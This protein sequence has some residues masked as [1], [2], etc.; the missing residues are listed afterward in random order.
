[1]DGYALCQV[2]ELI[3]HA[4]P[5]I[6]SGLLDGNTLRHLQ[7]A[8]P[9][10]PPACSIGAFECRL[11]AGARQVDLEVCLREGGGGRASL[12]AGLP[13][14][15]DST[16]GDPRWARTIE[17]L[18]SWCHPG[19]PL[20]DTVPVV[21]L[22]LDVDESETDSA[23]PFVVF[24]LDPE[25]PFANGTM[26]TE[27]TEGALLTGL[28]LLAGDELGHSSASTLR[29]C[30]LALP[31]GTRLLH[32]AL[33]PTVDR[34]LLRIILRMEWRC[35]TAYLCHL[36]WRGSSTE[37]DAWLTRTCPTT[38]MSS[39]NLDLADGVGP[40]IGI[41]YYFPTQPASDPRWR[42]VFDALVEV[43]A[44]TEER[45]A[46]LEAW[47]SYGKEH[48]ETGLL[49]VEREL[50]LKVVYEQGQPLR[51]KAYLSFAPRLN[52]TALAGIASHVATE[53]F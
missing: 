14:F 28:N 46:Q 29:R 15:E 35:L 47:P 53:V 4:R 38:L 18:R 37:Q 41:E 20:F 11:E 17:F 32:A 25:A 43:G 3:A 33:R 9:A 50:L 30:L 7:D 2:A 19:S 31:S 27:R 16:R 39:I 5:H 23:V 48:E 52:V 42:T 36:G 22:E 1:M 49:R 21:W 34:D 10:L 26:L 13:E 24:T 45:R 6:P 12:A 51:A 44:C 40:R 8:L